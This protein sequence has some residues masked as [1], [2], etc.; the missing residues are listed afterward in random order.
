MINH[1]YY[2]ANKVLQLC[3]DIYAIGAPEGGNFVVDALV[4]GGNYPTTARLEYL[5]VSDGIS[6]KNELTKMFTE[7][8]LKHWEVVG[9]IF[10]GFTSDEVQYLYC[11]DEDNIV[12]LHFP[13]TMG[14]YVQNS[15]GEYY[16]PSAVWVNICSLVIREYQNSSVKKPKNSINKVVVIY[17]DKKCLCCG[18]SVK[19]GAVLE[20]SHI[21]PIKNGGTDDMDNLQT[22]C[23]ECHSGNAEN[24]FDFLH[25]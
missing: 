21:V 15:L 10:H 17:R 11:K 13:D 16:V 3:S 18:K 25:T 23:S 5:N 14:M 12:N 9:T 19:D 22:L 2:K 8:T 6:D 1:E 24:H 7:L 4:I 20:V